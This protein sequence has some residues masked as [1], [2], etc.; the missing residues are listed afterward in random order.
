MLHDL[1]SDWRL[2]EEQLGIDID[3]R[4]FAYLHSRDD[5]L[6]QALED[7]AGN[8]IEIDRRQ[9]RFGALLSLLWPR[10]NTIR[11]HR[12]SVYNPFAHL[13]DAEHDLVRDCLRGGPEVVVVTESDWRSQA[14]DCLV[15]DSAVVLRAD[16]KETAGLRKALISM[17]SEPVDTDFMLLH[18]RV[19][20]IE[21]GAG[22][23][24]VTLELA[25]GIQ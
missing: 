17:M 21:R 9:W 23:I 6:D 25:E 15:R 20:G 5:T 1:I 13:P 10:G 19:R 7:V 12:L 2:R 18:P 14:A 22:A 16:A 3:A 11:G 4:V 24:D 8:A